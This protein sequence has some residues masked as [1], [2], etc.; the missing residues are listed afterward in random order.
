[1]AGHIHAGLRGIADGLTPPE[2]VSGDAYSRT[3]LPR[4]PRTLEEATALFAHSDLARAV[5]GDEAHAC[6]TATLQDEVTAELAG[7]GAGPDPD[8]GW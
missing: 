8:G 5:L 1:M 2:A 6:L 3:D 7:V 4:L